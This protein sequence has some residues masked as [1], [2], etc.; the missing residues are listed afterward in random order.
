MIYTKA[1]EIILQYFEL[2]G[3]AE[4]GS[5]TFMAT[6]T[7]TVT[8]FLRRRNNYD[9]INFKIAIDKFFKDYQD[10]TLNRVEKPVAK[11][12][13]HVWAG[14]SLADYKI[15]LSKQ[16]NTAIATSE[17]FTESQK[18]IKFKNE[19]EFWNIILDKGKDKLLYFILAYPQQ[20]VIIKSGQRDEEKRFL[21]YEF[22][23][24]R[25]SEG[26]HPFQRSKTI[27]E[28]TRLYDTEVF[29]N[30]EKVST[31]IYKAFQGEQV[32]IH[33]S[34]EKNITRQSLV[35]ML[36]FDRVDF[37]KNISTSIKKS[38]G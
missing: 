19:N 11:Y 24:R 27:D 33:P 18:K 3:I 4:L 30:P 16:P 38:K 7:N 10:V 20:I 35:D 1:R 9:S 25:G 31:Y 12:V 37:E 5:N 15:L 8:L 32:A 6:G 22:S 34:L 28:C 2:I 13:K 29:D 21:G 26:I 36:S 14:C 17:I 23:F